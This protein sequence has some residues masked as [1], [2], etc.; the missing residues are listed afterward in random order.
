MDVQKIIDQAKPDKPDMARMSFLLPVGLHER[1]NR[2][3]K[4]MGADRTRLLV[5]AV[6]AL[7]VVMENS[8]GDKVT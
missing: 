2:L 4:A 3:A 7:V 5:G 1:F 8:D 6:E